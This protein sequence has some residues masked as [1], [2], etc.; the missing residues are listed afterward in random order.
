MATF[1]AL[2]D[3]NLLV[4]EGNHEFHLLLEE[5][6]TVADQVAISLPKTIALEET[7]FTLTV[8]FRTRATKT[9][10]TPTTIRYRIDDLRSDRE[11]RDWTSVSV[12]PNVSIV[13][14]ATDNEIKDD[15]ALFERRQ[16]IVQADQGLSTQVNGK[17]IWKVKNLLGIT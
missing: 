15:S 13:I 12:A 10:S 16:I 1:L 4:L 9:A 3:G 8:F 2:E 7:S 5:N 17:A 14:S 11:I 6:T